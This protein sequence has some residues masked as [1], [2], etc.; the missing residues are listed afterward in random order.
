LEYR[1]I[2]AAGITLFVFTFLLNNLSYYMNKKLEK[3]YV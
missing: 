2:F 3:K 1:T